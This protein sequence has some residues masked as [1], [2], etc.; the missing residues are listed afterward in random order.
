MRIVGE[1]GDRVVAVLARLEEER[2]V[3][4]DRQEAA[5]VSEAQRVGRVQVGGPDRAPDFT[6]PFDLGGVLVVAPLLRPVLV[7]T[8][9]RGDVGRESVA[10]RPGCGRAG[11]DQGAS[12]P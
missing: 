5:R 3:A 1:L 12:A 7:V 6:C 9:R 4:P 10:G 11:G 8:T 2:V